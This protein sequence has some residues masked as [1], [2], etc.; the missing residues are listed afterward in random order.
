M[1][2]FKLTVILTVVQICLG[3][4][5]IIIDKSQHNGLGEGSNQEIANLV[6]NIEFYI[7]SWLGIDDIVNYNFNSLTYLL[8]V[9]FWL[10]VGLLMDLI[11]NR[12]SLRSDRF[13]QKDRL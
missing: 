12:I 13:E 3:A 8:G 6:T 2:R 10:F 1:K 9:V 11:R 7:K 4:A 5:A